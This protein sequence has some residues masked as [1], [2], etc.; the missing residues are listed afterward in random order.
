MPRRKNKPKQ[1][2][3]RG[4]IRQKGRGQDAAPLTPLSLHPKKRRV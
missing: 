3:H 4:K 1:F 2:N